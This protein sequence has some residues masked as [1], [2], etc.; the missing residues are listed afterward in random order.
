MRLRQPE[1]LETRLQKQLDPVYLITGDEP[2][3]LQEAAD[4]VRAAARAAG[5]DEREVFNVDGGFDWGDLLSSGNNLSLFASRRLLELRCQSAAPGK[6]GARVLGE[7][8]A[9]TSGDDVLLVLMPRLDGRQQQSKWYKALTA[10]GVHLPV[11]PVELSAFPRWLEQRLRKAGVALDSDAFDAL[12]AR[13]EGNLLAAGQ[14]VTRLQSQSRERS[15]TLSELVAEFDD[16]SRYTAFELAEQMFAG[17]PEQVHHML[18]T[19]RQEG[20]EVLSIVGPLAWN[21][22]QLAAVM[23]GGDSQRMPRARQA[24]LQRARQRLSLALVEGALRDLALVDQ[25]AKGLLELDP[26]DEL[27][28]LTLRLAGV[29]TTPLAL[30]ARTWLSP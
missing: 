2:L 26:W 21:L 25:A 1:E 13:V 15:W 30:R 23:R 19:L 4:M 12:V 8:L 16:D 17:R 6:E 11:W 28:R 10:E 20:V 22:R 7:Y 5:V 9:Q 3:L 27:D 18:A 14:A 29:R 24:V